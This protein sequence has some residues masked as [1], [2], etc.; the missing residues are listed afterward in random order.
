MGSR[1]SLAWGLALLSAG[2][3]SPSYHNGD[4]HCTASGQCP[5]NFHC[6]AVDNTCWHNGS[7][8]AANTLPT[9][10][11]ATDAAAKDVP[12]SGSAEAGASGVQ[13]DQ[14][15]A[16]YALVVCTANFAC[17]SQADL[18]GKTLASCE[19][20][21]ASKFQ[22]VVQAISDG[23]ARGR[24]IYYPER[25]RLCLQVIGNAT[26]QAWPIDPETQL[27]ILCQKVIEPQVSS[28]GPCRTAAEC[29]S[30]LCTGASSTADGTCLPKAPS[31]ESCVQI[32]AQNSCQ[33]GLY[34]DSTSLCSSTKAEGTSCAQNRECASQNCNAVPDAGNLCLPAPC[35]S[36]GPLLE[37]AC[38]FGGR[39]SAFASVLALAVLG[40]LV[41]RRPGADRRRG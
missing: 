28:G 2:C 22:P 1:L 5:E 16:E 23:V 18:K 6:A 14:L 31:G 9:D 20:N 13:I 32:L 34:C 27:P 24:T 11:A 17:C 3:F 12:A 39:P 35:Y 26:C 36:N 30:E 29:V 38:S 41:R 10:A 21:V 15:A 33:S 8:P 4:L 19:Q 40:L 7:D 25:A 37:P